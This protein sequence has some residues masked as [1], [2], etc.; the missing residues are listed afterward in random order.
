MKSKFLAI[1]AAIGL[2]AQPAYAD[3]HPRHHFDER[4]F[5][6]FIYNYNPVYTGPIWLGYDGIYR[7]VR[8]YYGTVGHLT[9]DWGVIMTRYNYYG[10]PRYRLRCR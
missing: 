9:N 10:T 8:P 5:R 7:C 1:L 3:H 4:E 2:A 6:L